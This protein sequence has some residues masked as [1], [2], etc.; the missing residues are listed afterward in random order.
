ME[1]SMLA[2]HFGLGMGLK[3]AAP[4]LSLGTLFL[5]VQLADL[6][7]PLC[8]LLGL[9]HVRIAPG[10]T[11]LTPLDFTDYPVTHSLLGALAWSAVVG[12]LYSLFT[13]RTAS[14]ATLSLGVL[15]HWFLD[16][17]V[18]RRDLQL[19]PDGPA[20][21]FGLWDSFYATLA[22]EGSLFVLGATLYVR[23]TRA[24]D[25]QGRFGLVALLVM[26]PVL[27][28]A[29]WFGPPPPD[30]RSLAFGALAMWLFVPWGYWVDRHRELRARAAAPPW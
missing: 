6:V 8:L 5:A 25:A 17:I 11:R 21:G 23:L 15:S 1:A 7:W 19:V 27:Q 24:R 29:A 18:H 2:G 22:V 13:G 16:L 28:L 14:A 3:R 26:F 10:I 30:T 4:E 12:G 9:E 20:F